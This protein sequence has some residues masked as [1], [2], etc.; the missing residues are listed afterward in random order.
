[1]SL[2]RLQLVY[3]HGSKN[4]KTPRANSRAS[5]QLLP[6]S[7][8]QPNSDLPSKI[9]WLQNQHPAVAQIVEEIVDGCIA[10]ELEAAKQQRQV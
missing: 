4:S 6:S 10:R 9:A 8:L 5:S 3:S 2:P 1:M 7:R